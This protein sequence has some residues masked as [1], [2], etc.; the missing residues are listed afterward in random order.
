MNITDAT[1]ETVAG[2]EITLEAKS[3]NKNDVLDAIYTDLNIFSSKH[4][5][6]QGYSTPKSYASNMQTDM[7][8]YKR[9]I[10][11]DGCFYIN[12]C[13]RALAI[14]RVADT[15][16]NVSDGPCKVIVDELQVLENEARKIAAKYYKDR[17]VAFYRIVPMAQTCPGGSRSGKEVS[18]TPPEHTAASSI[19]PMILFFP[20]HSI[21]DLLYPLDLEIGNADDRV[22]LRKDTVLNSKNYTGLNF[23]AAFVMPDIAVARTRIGR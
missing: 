7:A 11:E 18:A 12:Q 14:T 17:L 6:M 5:S 1:F 2:C 15:K 8:G 10:S 9:R 13:G 21:T 20:L 4:P 19:A 3:L 16:I 23:N 22:A